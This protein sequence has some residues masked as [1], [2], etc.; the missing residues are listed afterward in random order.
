[1]DFIVDGY[2]GTGEKSWKTEDINFQEWRYSQTNES[3]YLS[4][5]YDL[6]LYMY[7]YQQINK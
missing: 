2:D 5:I 6:Y 7:I 4:M 1:M 3:I